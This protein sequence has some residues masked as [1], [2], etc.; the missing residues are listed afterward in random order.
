[1]GV[2][3]VG[4]HERSGRSRINTNQIEHVL[5]DETTRKYLQSVK[6]LLTVCEKEYGQ[7][8]TA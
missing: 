1:M 3:M 7:L 8:S 4:I 2:N 5:N 6:R